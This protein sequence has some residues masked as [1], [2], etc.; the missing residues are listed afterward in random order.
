[1]QGAREKGY[2]AEKNV[3]RRY[4]RGREDEA[5]GEGYDSRKRRKGRRSADKQAVKQRKEG[6]D[7]YYRQITEGR[8][9]GRKRREWAR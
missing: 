7:G 4:E 8:G 9:T 1:M 3:E 6:E 2:F 5:D